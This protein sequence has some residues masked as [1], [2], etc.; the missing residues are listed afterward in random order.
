MPE[1]LPDPSA[2]ALR[3]EFG[4]DIIAPSALTMLLSAASERPRKRV[5]EIGTAVGYSALCLAAVTG[6][7]WTPWKGTPQGWI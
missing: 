2:E 4:Y 3:S 1:F 6:R 7:K 5:L